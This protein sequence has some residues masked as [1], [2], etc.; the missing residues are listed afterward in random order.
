MSLVWEG[1]SLNRTHAIH[2][3]CPAVPG[4]SEGWRLYSKTYGVQFC[5]S[6]THVYAV[7]LLNVAI[8]LLCPIL[9]AFIPNG[10]GVIWILFF[11]P[12]I[13]PKF[14]ISFPPAP[15]MFCRN[16]LLT[17]TVSCHSQKSCYT[18]MGSLVTSVI[19]NLFSLRDQGTLSPKMARSSPLQSEK[20]KRT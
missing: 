15:F 12:N 6:K 4:S 11:A 16:I 17:A 19:E 5:P 14:E 20:T 3:K 18:N 1:M 10:A 8:I 13:C 9:F 7:V 2:N